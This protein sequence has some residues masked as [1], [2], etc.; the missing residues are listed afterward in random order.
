MWKSENKMEKSIVVLEDDI[1]LAVLFKDV[2]ELQGFSVSAFVKPNSALE[3]FKNK[4]F[5]LILTNYIMPEMNGIEFARKVR[6]IDKE[7]RIWLLTGY[8]VGRIK[9]NASF[10]SANIE[11]IIE[12]PV[13][14]NELVDMVKPLFS[15]S[16][17]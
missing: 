6:E 3:R 13:S 8:S 1:D 5:S 17:S 2:L 15:D 9:E 12:K 11:K 10:D 16:Y 14:I 4:G 7:V